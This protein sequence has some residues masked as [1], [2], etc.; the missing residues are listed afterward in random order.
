MSLFPLKTLK[1]KLTQ[2][3]VILEMVLLLGKVMNFFCFSIMACLYIKH[4]MCK[5]VFLVVYHIHDPYL[6]GIVTANIIKHA[7]KMP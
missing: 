5:I 2:R 3:G 6:R 1:N 7:E 4:K